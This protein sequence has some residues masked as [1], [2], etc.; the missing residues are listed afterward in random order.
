MS[1]QALNFTQ[2]KYGLKQIDIIV[3]KNRLI[4]KYSMNLERFSNVKIERTSVCVCHLKCKQSYHLLNHGL[5]LMTKSEICIWEKLKLG[6]APLFS[7]CRYIVEAVHFLNLKFQA[8]SQLLS[9]H[10]QP[11]LC[12]SQLEIHKNMFSQI[13]SGIMVYLS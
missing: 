8:F 11:G 12:R 5:F 1:K 10:V 7:H 3:L 6:S 4:F 13:V 2:I 9:L